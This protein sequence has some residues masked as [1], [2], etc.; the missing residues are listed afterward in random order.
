MPFV[1]SGSTVEEIDGTFWRLAQPLVYRGAS[2]EF[3]V[4]AGF[5]TDF[6]SVPRAL[7]WL[8]PRYGA[9]TRAAILHDYLRAG[10]VVR[11]ADADGIFRR[12]LREFGVSVPRRWMMWAAVRV[13]SGLAGASAGDL[14]RFLLVAVPAVLFLAIPVLV[15]SLALWVFWVVELLFWSGARLTRRTEGPAPRPEMKTA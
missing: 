5:R 2:Q 8:I 12:S 7:V 13:G 9:Y 10:A 4:P 1:G 3:T 14:L 15:V 11:A 6:A